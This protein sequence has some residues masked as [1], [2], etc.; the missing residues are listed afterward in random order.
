M[1]CLQRSSYS[2][3]ANFNVTANVFC[4]LVC[5]FV[6]SFSQTGSCYVAM[7]LCRLSWNSLCWPGWPRH[8][9]RSTCLCL[10]SAGIKG[11]L[12]HTWLQLALKQCFLCQQT[13]IPVS[14]DSIF[15]C[16]YKF[17]FQISFFVYYS[18][19]VIPFQLVSK[20][21]VLQ[22]SLCIIGTLEISES[23]DV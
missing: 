18:T 8:S 4:Q 13:L 5:C 2:L 16:S 15:T 22:W 10:W 20:L 14:D 12:H 19:I 1:Y 7:Y 6:F 11:M 3:S 21:Y 23:V 17:C 9:Q